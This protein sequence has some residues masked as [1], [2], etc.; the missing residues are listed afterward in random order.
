M[1]HELTVLENNKSY[2]SN[3]IDNN[4]KIVQ[5]LDAKLQQEFY[6]NFLE[7][8]TND[9]LVSKVNPQILLKFCI[10]VTLMGL[11]IN[12]A[13]KEVYIVPYNTEIRKGTPKVMLP[14]AIIPLNGIQERVS[15]Q[16]FF[17]RLYEVYNFDGE[18]VSEK[19]M[20]RKHQVLLDTTNQQW[21]D[22]HFVGCATC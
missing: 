12:P 18:I 21:F 10:S 8:A 3:L 11:N 17:L 2:L 6:K 7:L 15:K 5:I 13:Y 1:N 16:G 4:Q 22:K 20:Q 19:E 14:Q 9:Y